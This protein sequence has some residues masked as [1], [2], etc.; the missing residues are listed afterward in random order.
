[1]SQRAEGLPGVSTD[2][3]ATSP[4]RSVVLD[5]FS[6]N[7]DGISQR[8]AQRKTLLRKLDAGLE[9]L[10]PQKLAVSLVCQFITSDL[11]GH[12][13]GQTT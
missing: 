1:M 6:V 4:E 9:Q 8:L 5:G 2:Y 11:T 13:D 12:S 3:H 10:L 7:A